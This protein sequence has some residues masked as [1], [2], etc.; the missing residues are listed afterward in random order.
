MTWSIFLQVR[1]IAMR[2]NELFLER[3]YIENSKNPTVEHG[4]HPYEE[5]L[6]GWRKIEIGKAEIR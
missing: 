5:V 3:A 4:R 1:V 2:V 6:V